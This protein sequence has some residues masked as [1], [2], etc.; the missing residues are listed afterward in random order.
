MARKAFV[1]PG[2][3]LG[4]IEEF[5]TSQGTYEDPN[6]RLRASL[7]GLALLDNYRKIATVKGFKKVMPKSG[8]VV[9]GLV[10]DVSK[11]LALV[12]IYAIENKYATLRTDFRAFLH[13]SQVSSEYV[14]TMYDAVRA[15]DYV[16]AKVLN[17]FPP[18]QLTIK[19]PGLG[20]ILATCSSCGSPLSLSNGRLTCRVC[21]NLER[22]KVSPLYIFKA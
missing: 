8:D 14:A 18:F 3:E 16:K 17:N 21:G 6:G 12:K 10:E 13:I 20:V 15:G 22:R 19:E 4:V 9:E 2:D 1:T 5:V 7:T 11:D